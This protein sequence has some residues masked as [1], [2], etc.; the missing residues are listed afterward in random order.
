M[1]VDPRKTERVAERN[2]VMRLRTP[3]NAGGLSGLVV[4]AEKG[5]GVSP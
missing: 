1:T 2:S 3:G 5:G 4:V